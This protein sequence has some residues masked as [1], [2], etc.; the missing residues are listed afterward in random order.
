MV[1]GSLDGRGVRV[2]MDTCI[3]MTEFLCYPLETIIIL[4]FGYVYAL[5]RVQLYNSTNRSLPGSSVHGIFQARILEVIW[6]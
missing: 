3:R 1:C 5:S 6:V 4:L 2:R